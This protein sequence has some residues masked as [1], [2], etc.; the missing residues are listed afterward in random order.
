MDNGGRGSDAG[1]YDIAAALLRRLQRL[2]GLEHLGVEVSAHLDQRLVLRF[3]ARVD[4][5]AVGTDQIAFHGVVIEV[6][7]SSVNANVTQQEAA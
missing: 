4:H 5:F 3:A 2:D 6:V 1:A 7:R